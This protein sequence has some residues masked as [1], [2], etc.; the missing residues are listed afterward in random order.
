MTIKRLPNLW[1]FALY[2]VATVVISSAERRG[3]Y[4][5]VEPDAK[6][7]FMNST[8][9][10]IACSCQGNPTPQ[11]T[12]IKKDGTP[13]SDITGLRHTRP[14]GT[15]VFPPFRAEEY[16]QDVHAA[17]YRC[18]ARNVVGTI[19]S[20]D[21]HIRAAVMQFYET[22]V[23][24][25]FVTKGNTAVLKC[26]IP[27]FVKEYVSVMS[28]M[29]DDGH[30]IHAEVTAGGRYSVFSTG[31]LYIRQ[32]DSVT[33]GMRKFYCQTKHRIS[34]AIKQSSSSGR[35]IVTEPHSTF[36][37]RII[38]RKTSLIGKQGTTVELPCAAEGYPVPSI[39]W[40]KFE[41]SQALR[42]A[43]NQRYVQLGGTLI[44][45][46]A[47][48]ED[49]GKYICYVNNSVAD[50]RVH[51]E[52]LIAAPLKVSVTP[53]Q[54]KVEEGESIIFN[55][56]IKGHP[57]HS[58]T[59]VKNLNPIVAN[60]RIRYLS[61]DL[62]QV[63]PI[64]RED[65]GMYQCFVT[66]DF[67][68]S[69]GSAELNLGD[70]P[71]VLAYTFPEQTLEPGSFL[72]LKCT[73]TGTPLPQITWSLDGFPVTEGIRT[74]VGDFVTSDG[75]V[76]SFVNITRLQPEDGGTYECLGS[77]DIATVG[78]SAR[79]NVYGPPFVKPMRNISVLAGSNLVI[80]C[81]VSGYPIEK[82]L[83]EKGESKLPQNRRQQVFPNGTLIINTVDRNNDEGSYRCIAENKDGETA[84]RDV[85]VKVLVAPVINPF[86]FPNN[87]KEGNRVIITCSILDGDTPINLNW[88]KD[89]QPIIDNANMRVDSTNEFMSVLY[90]KRVTYENNGNYTCV[91]S[92][93]AD[94][95]NFTAPMVVNV[96]PQWKIQ[97]T[98]K[99]VVVGQ[100]V[101]IDCQADGFPQPRIW[102]EKS[103]I[104]GSRDYKTIISNSHI[105]ALENGSLMIRESE[106]NDAGYYLCQATNGIGSGLS[107]VI[108]LTVHVAAY[109]KGKFVAQTLKKGESSVLFCEAFGE[110]PIT[111]LWSKDRQPFDPASDPRYEMTTESR[112]DSLISKI[113][114]HS[115]D[116]R[117]SALFTCVATNAYGQD[118][119]NLQLIVQEAPDSPGNIL[120][121][122]IGSRTITIRWAAPYS[123]NSPIV[124]YKVQHKLSSETWGDNDRTST[125]SGRETS[126]ILRGLRPVTSYHVR[127]MAEN[128]IGWSEPS[129]A[130]HITTAEEA[131]EGVPTAVHA[132][133][134]SSNT[135]HVSWQPPKKE[136]RHGNVKGYYVGYKPYGGAENYI[137]QTVEVQGDFKE[138]I[139]L[140]NL[141]R[142]TKYS[143]IVQAFN[144]KGSGPPCE[145]LIVDTLQNDPP[146]SP[147]L[148][149]TSATTSTVQLKWSSIENENSP[150]TGYYIFFKKEYETWEE[151]QVPGHQTSYTFQDL[152]CGSHY[153]F[154]IVA[155]NAVGKGKPSEVIAGK[156]SGT[157][158]NPPKRDALLSINSTAVT[159][160]LNT[161]L[162]GAC[163]V[164]FFIVQYKANTQREWILVSNNIVPEQKTST[165][166]DLT[167]ATWYT[168]LMTAHS[169]AG[170][171]E[172]E[173]VFATLT[174]YGATVPPPL[175]ID[176]RRPMIYRSLSILVPTV[177][178]AVV[179][180]VILIVAC[181]VVRRRRQVDNPNRR[182]SR[183]RDDKSGEGMSMAVMERKQQGSAGSGSPI[184][185]QLYYPSPYAMSHIPMF[186][187]QGSPESDCSQSLRR[188]FGRHEHIY[189]VPYP[190]KWREQETYSHIMENTN[191][192]IH[193][194][195]N[196]YQTPRV[197]PV[198]AVRA[199][200]PSHRER[201]SSKSR[202]SHRLSYK[203]SNMA[204]EGHSGDESENETTYIF[205]RELPASYLD[206]HEMSEAEC[207]R[208]LHEFCEKIML[209]SFQMKNFK[210]LSNTMDRG[211]V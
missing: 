186:Q 79:L 168:I 106:Q 26:H 45:R 28:W 141:R 16:R 183:F 155:Y 91:A 20:R 162:G 145:E 157:A 101:I 22:Q 8:G 122:E 121:T 137:Y 58:V 53:K 66:N 123:G 99:S 103:E 117:D 192:A 52:L 209:V 75:F 55:C 30:I 10:A 50:E 198:H 150:I 111:I 74:R 159:L 208:D 151:R 201:R 169:E 18:V 132:V 178:A 7:E 13:L 96:P 163:P 133:A 165:I 202:N 147:N 185:D 84:F 206:T 181:V 94:V 78:H 180:V 15:L 158:P 189:D 210:Y 194:S 27:S 36:P 120:A 203:M 98:D 44:I 204:S 156:T 76:N 24:D 5:A 63:A 108:E 83:W 105:H 81:P 153:Q 170:P 21:V 35:V 207:D 142:A 187:K 46:R 143:I 176:E 97:P 72:S 172:A 64:V 92:N 128:G 38:D 61:R 211:Y 1:M 87:L 112:K 149:I 100:N 126:A 161:W 166:T 32:A 68:M 195:N 40:L 43:K 49:S 139:I 9:A 177:C 200:T 12:W 11:V 82:I 184:K 34:G 154:Y 173:Y 109:F 140:T 148:T 47:E 102:W 135:I 136:L 77:N 93:R 56:S 23:Y 144:G 115:V 62:L 41:K 4:F 90:M 88:Y 104:T 69:Q 171:T 95:V 73:A 51:T 29:R 3:P 14:D 107:K 134:S 86:H 48:P 54:V 85:E 60:S 129:Q 6:V 37:P 67:G 127:V 196:L 71:P 199:S 131:P 191:I 146:V 114:I 42:L 197:I 39:H 65:K 124:S 70:D 19:A 138:E 2:A 193:P 113:S 57:I 125:I 164:N 167:P 33:D 188:D 116:R 80:K 119:T 110:S 160:H 25:V 17:V 190:P 130:V 205:N 152:Y 31:E 89:N 182:D 174:A 179:L 175:S 59:W 118:D